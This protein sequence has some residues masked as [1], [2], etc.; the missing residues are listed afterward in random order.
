MPPPTAWAFQKNDA[1]F[2]D[3]PAGA[4]SRIV[5]YT[6]VVNGRRIELPKALR[7]VLRT[8]LLRVSDDEPITACAIHDHYYTVLEAETGEGQTFRLGG[9][10]MAAFDGDTFESDYTRIEGILDGDIEITVKAGQPVWQRRG[11]AA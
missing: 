2:Y 7:I 6:N 3:T 5:V 9:A 10:Y 11:A 8:F 1:L 4:P